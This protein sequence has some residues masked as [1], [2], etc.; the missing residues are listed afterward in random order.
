MSRA[1]HTVN[2]KTV[3]DSESGT[4]IVTVDEDFILESL[5]LETRKDGG[6]EEIRTST[7]TE[8]Y[9]KSQS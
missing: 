1:D 4:G 8:M 7:V 3:N 5:D 9:H 2:S 6:I